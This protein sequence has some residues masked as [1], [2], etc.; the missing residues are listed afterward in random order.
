MLWLFL[1][2]ISWCKILLIDAAY[3]QLL[4]LETGWVK[5]FYEILESP[6]K[7]HLRDWGFIHTQTHILCCNVFAIVVWVSPETVR[8]VNF[9]WI[10]L[11][12]HLQGSLDGKSWTNL[13]VHENDQTVCKP[14]QFASWPIIGPNALL[15]FRFFRVIMTGQTSDAS[16]L[17]NFCICFLELYGY[18]H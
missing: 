6:G 15:P 1:W 9:D 16:N 10:F 4:H 7:D 5:G 13:R 8:W 18:F 3:V 14:G 2:L 11:L 12:M 17:W